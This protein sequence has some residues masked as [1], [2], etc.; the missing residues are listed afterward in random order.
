MT[1]KS[2]PEASGPIPSLKDKDKSKEILATPANLE[3]LKTLVGEEGLPRSQ[4]ELN[5]LLKLTQEMVKKKGEDWVKK[6]RIALLRQ[7]E[8]VRTLL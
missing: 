4:K 2:R 6:N 3:E 1:K 5:W 7:W 8:Y